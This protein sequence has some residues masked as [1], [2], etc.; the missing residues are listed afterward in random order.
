MT[1]EKPS[2]HDIRFVLRHL[3]ELDRRELLAAGCDLEAL[4]ARSL[5]GSVFCFCAVDGAYLPQAVWGM[6]EQ[7]KGVG[8]GFAFGTR[9]WG[10]ALPAI[11]KN[12]KRFVLPFL[13]THGY[14]R[15]E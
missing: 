2:E 4:P 1:T 6:M 9:H 7:R 13:H 11:M 10:K 12:I 3:R 8:T 15:V 14:H 5:A